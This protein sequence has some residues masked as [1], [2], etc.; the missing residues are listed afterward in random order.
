MTPTA[1]SII[2]FWLNVLR[3]S[4]SLPSPRNIAISVDVPVAIIRPTEKIKIV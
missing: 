3:A 2:R 4:S 1:T